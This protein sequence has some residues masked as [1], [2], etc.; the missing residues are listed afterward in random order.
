MNIEFKFRIGTR[1][2]WEATGFEGVIETA[3]IRNTSGN[4]E[5]IVVAYDG[6]DFHSRWVDEEFLTVA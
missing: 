3:A 6:K 5:Y 2:K 4:K 1:V